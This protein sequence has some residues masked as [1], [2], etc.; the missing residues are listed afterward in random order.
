MSENHHLIRSASATSPGWRWPILL[1][2]GA[3]VLIVVPKL[4]W[5][6]KIDW[7]GLPQDIGVALLLVAIVEF[8]V[9]RPLEQR[10]Q[11]GRDRRATLL[12]AE[13]DRQE[14]HEKAERDR[15]AR[16]E[17]A[18]N[19]ILKSMDTLDKQAQEITTSLQDFRL[20]LV[21]EEA[22]H[23]RYFQQGFIHSLQA[24]LPVEAAAMVGKAKSFGEGF[25]AQNSLLD[26]DGKLEYMSL[27]D[28]EAL[29]DGE[30][31][32]VFDK[33]VAEHSETRSSSDVGREDVMPD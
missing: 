30:A 3:F 20:D 18:E 2:S 16:M 9:L 14:R 31:R 21:L 1:A 8:M 25:A 15:Q 33:L 5:P 11:A 6:D 4:M 23:V 17:K 32:K 7:W 19:D 12:Q 29:I 13:R 22:R 26:Q 28:Y 10:E 24:S 27:E